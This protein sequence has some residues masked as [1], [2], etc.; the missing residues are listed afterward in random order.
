M[1]KYILFELSKIKMGDT[2]SVKLSLK[3]LNTG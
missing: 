2:E 1:I 3:M